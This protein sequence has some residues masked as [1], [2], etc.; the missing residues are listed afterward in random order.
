MGLLDWI[1]VVGPLLDFAGDMMGRS[2]QRRA[3]Q[4]NIKMQREQQTWE[5]RMSNT[6]VQRR[7]AD[8]KAAGG[9]PALAFTGGQEA[10]TPT[11][12][13][14]RV[15]P[16]TPPGGFTAK[17]VALASLAQ[18]K[19][20]TKK[21]LADARITNVEADIREKLAGKELDTRANRFVEENEW[22]DL[23]TRIL[24]NTDVSTA[25][26]AKRL[27]DTVDEMITM[28][29]QSARTG[30]LNLEALENIAKVGG[31]E[32]GKVQGI[33]KLF[34]DLYRTTKD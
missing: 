13:P 11:L 7:V 31:V 27:R 17:A 20:Q 29:K 16:L 9:N 4:D 26:E 8:I 25:A 28:A 15:E 14:A 30:T 21:T 32:A 24:R 23:K 34:L 18:V 12:A 2:D 33:L 19:A 5:E 6:A 10:S 22:N 3:N 1:P